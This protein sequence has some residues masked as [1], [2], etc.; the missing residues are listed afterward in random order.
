ML[1]LHFGLAMVRA[2]KAQRG[3]SGLAGLQLNKVAGLKGK[4]FPG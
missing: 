1:R 3:R 4:S 2:S